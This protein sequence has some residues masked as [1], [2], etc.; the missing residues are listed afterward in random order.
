MPP[1]G[2]A[3]MAVSSGMRFRST[4]RPG[5]TAALA[6]LRDQIRAARQRARIA[7]SHRRDGIVDGTG[8]LI[9]EFL[10]RSAPLDVVGRNRR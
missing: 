2:N 6:Q 4:M 7:D 9:D 3:A 5:P 10:Q 8:A 1:S